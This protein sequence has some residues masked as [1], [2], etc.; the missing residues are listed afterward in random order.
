MEISHFLNYLV[1]KN[2]QHIKLS[3]SIKNAIFNATNIFFLL[4][5]I[6]GGN[7][8]SM[9]Q[10]NKGIGFTNPKGKEFW[11]AYMANLP[12]PTNGPPSFFLYIHGERA[13]KGEVSIPGRTDVIP[14]TVVPNQLTKVTIPSNVRYPERSGETRRCGIKITSE[15]DIDVV[16]QHYRPF[17][18]E[19]SRILPITQLGTEYTIL[20]KAAEFGKSTFVVLAIEDNTQIE[21]TPSDDTEDDQFAGQKFS[22]TLKKGEVYQLHSFGNLSGS[23]VK[24]INNKKIAVFGGAAT[25][26]SWVNNCVGQ[27]ADSHL[28]EQL[29][30]NQYFARE[31]FVAPIGEH[32]DMKLQIVTKENK[33]TNITVNGTIVNVQGNREIVIGQA[34]YIVAD[35]PI[36]I[37]F[38]M[39][40][41]GCNTVGSAQRGDPSMF[42]AAPVGSTSRK[43]VFSTISDLAAFNTLNA[44]YLVQLF[45]PKKF[46]NSLRLDG[47]PVKQSFIKNF[48][49]RSDMVWMDLTID[50]GLHII[51]CDT[52]IQGY[53]YGAGGYDAY[54]FGLNGPGDP[55]F[56]GNPGNNGGASDQF[57]IKVFPNPFKDSKLKVKFHFPPPPVDGFFELNPTFKLYDEVGRLII[58]EKNR[59]TSNNNQIELPTEYLAPAIYYLRITFDKS[60]YVFK[61]YK[62]E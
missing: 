61:V 49:G 2:I 40:S 47:D 45:V 4:L 32:G 59:V 42:V 29:P 20:A 44:D 17:F 12:L 48:P 1:I 54:S 23:I 34:T 37:A 9:A 50:S 30:P 6:F 7:R 46:V 26:V 28:W 51:E 38:F 39:K 35:D 10:G 5:V 15:D 31:Y 55:N 52:G 27:G 3:F 8:N 18:N 19:S 36:A 11:L 21:I 57:G 24:C 60:V 13:T 25:S 14:F 43:F 22:I 62:G 16:A 41:N 53:S 33:T 56:S 58:E